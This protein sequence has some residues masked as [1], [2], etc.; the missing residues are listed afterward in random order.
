M[1][2]R[3]L[4][5]AALLLSTL[6]TVTTVHAAETWRFGNRVIV[7]GDSIATLRQVA[8]AP[9]R[10]VTLE[11]HLG[12]A[13]GERWEYFLPGGRMVAFVIHRGAIQAIDNA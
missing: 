1:H 8:G 9:D 4:V 7:V 6:A 10:I 13:V 5:L 2:I 3:S 11:N 12:A